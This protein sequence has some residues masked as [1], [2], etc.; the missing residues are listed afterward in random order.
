[1][2]RTR[3][4]TASLLVGA[5]MA[6]GQILLPHVAGAAIRCQ[7]V[8]FLGARGSGQQE[9][10]NSGYG[11]E[12]D[13]VRRV[14][15]TELAGLRVKS[16][17]VQY[18]SESTNT[19]Y[20]TQKQAALLLPLTLP[21][22]QVI[23]SATGSAAAFEYYNTRYKTYMRSIQDGVDEILLILRLRRGCANERILLAGYSQGAIAMHRAL[24]TL[25][26]NRESGILNRIDGIALIA[27]GDRRP[28]ARGE[29]LGAPAAAS[30]S[31]IASYFQDQKRDL[32]R[33]LKQATINVCD[34][35]DLV[36][37]FAWS[38]IKIGVGIHTSYTTRTE[39]SAAARAIAG[40]VK[41][42]AAPPGT[43]TWNQIAYRP[44]DSVWRQVTG[45]LT[46][47]PS[48]FRSGTRVTVSFT[49]TDV[50]IG[51]GVSGPCSFLPETDTFVLM[52]SFTYRG[53]YSGYEGAPGV[54]PDMGVLRLDSAIRPTQ[55]TSGRDL[56]HTFAYSGPA[57]VSGGSNP[58][59]RP[60]GLLGVL[61]ESDA[62]GAP[63]RTV[64]RIT[65]QP[66]G[67]MR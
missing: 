63:M 19:L 60:V 32:P 8:L 45:R 44:D 52:P 67:L 9:K 62:T 13:A 23:G 47:S 25:S 39:L 20:P 7:D 14:V 15:E 54:S 31:G 27:D 5:I 56:V 22:G 41:R 48:T 10:D 35:G 33:S 4:L 55:C 26:D 40:K 2:A 34:K 57:T 29:L 64:M 51:A 58:G 24:L 42:P 21:G 3:I 12:M 38:N 53:G 30:G 46:M 6:A 49:M 17:R 43:S 36:C 11:P 37:D 28:G 61:D 1:M 16:M 59:I 50:L 66:V 18:A 65:G